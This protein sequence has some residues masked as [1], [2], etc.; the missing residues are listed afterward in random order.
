MSNLVVSLE[1]VAWD[2]AAG[3]YVLRRFERTDP[4][5]GPLLTCLGRAFITSVQLRVTSISN[6]RC[7]SYTN[8]PAGE[9]FDPSTLFNRTFSG[10][11]EAHG[12]VEIIHFPF[13]KHAWVTTWQISPSKPADSRRVTS[14]YNYYFSDNLPY[15]LTSLVRR[16]QTGAPSLATELGPL[17]HS[18]SAR[19]MIGSRLLDLWG[20][21]K[22]L[23][24]Y[25]RASTLR[26][27]ANGYA[28]HC[29]RSDVQRVVSEFYDYYEAKIRASAWSWRFP[30]N[31]PLE[32]RVTGVD[33]PADVG[34]P[35]AVTPS[36]SASRP[37]P[38]HPE[39]DT[40]VW[41]DILT[42]PGTPHSPQFFEECEQW[43]NRNYASYAGVRVEWSK[44]WGYSADGA[45][46]NPY[47]LGTLVPQSFGPEWDT[48]VETL[49]RL[50]PARIYAAPLHD[51]L[52]PQRGA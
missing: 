18:L 20:A 16:L 42:F 39:R 6:L 7:R 3:D 23:M 15:I 37:F 28:I 8:I 9:L 36:L 43:I 19:A 45:W 49:E 44:G 4:D 5:I 34:I 1:A 27:T 17:Q 33:D 52:M 21:P 29:R 22:N 26:V 31:G 12:R 48:A 13:T 40:V 30:I 32:V 25:V 11:L 14:P 38:D 51:A 24:L 35:G 10:L 46:S 2:D 50:D 47:T 41:L